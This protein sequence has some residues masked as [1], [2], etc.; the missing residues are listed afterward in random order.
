MIK[1]MQEPG[2]AI[3]YNIMIAIAKGIVTANDRKIL[4]E[5]RGTI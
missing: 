4:K 5:N 1:S 3:N 2:A